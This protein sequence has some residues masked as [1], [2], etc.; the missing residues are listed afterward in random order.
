MTDSAGIEAEVCGTAGQLRKVARRRARTERISV[1][2]SRAE[3]VALSK[4]AKAAHSS[5]GTYLRR[6]VLAYDPFTDQVDLPGLI[7]RICES[8]TQASHALTQA[9]ARC[10]E[11]DRRI[12]AMDAEQAARNGGRRL[13]MILKRA[14]KALDKSGNNRSIRRRPI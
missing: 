9:L 6:A 4:R 8:T 14:T 5:L 2:V 13:P 7:N 1:L 3:K 10:A 12:A 11:S